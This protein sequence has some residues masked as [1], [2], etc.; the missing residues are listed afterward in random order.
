M[1]IPRGP[2]KIEVGMM[3]KVEGLRDTRKNPH[4]LS[5]SNIWVRLRLFRMRYISK[6][7][8]REKFKDEMLVLE[9]SNSFPWRMVIIG[10]MI[11]IVFLFG[12]KC[13][14]STSNFD[15]YQLM[16]NG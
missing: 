2:L 16:E 12:W 14:K 7:D 6:E 5:R 9:S 3:P 8:L 15:H 1:G 13:F 4:W 10:F 11:L